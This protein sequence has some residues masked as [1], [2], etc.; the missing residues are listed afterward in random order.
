M[1]NLKSLAAIL[2]SAI[3]FSPAAFLRSPLRSEALITA[4]KMATNIDT[5]MAKSSGFHVSL[6]LRVYTP[7]Q[8]GNTQAVQPKTQSTH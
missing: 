5:N 2:Y 7:D 4:Q 8:D 3:R 1:L 6:L